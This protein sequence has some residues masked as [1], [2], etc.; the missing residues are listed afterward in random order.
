MSVKQPFKTRVI[1]YL[2][3]EGYKYMTWYRITSKL[4]K[5]NI[6]SVVCARAIPIQTFGAQVFVQYFL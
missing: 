2:F 3:E 1:R 6:A 4:Y 5:K